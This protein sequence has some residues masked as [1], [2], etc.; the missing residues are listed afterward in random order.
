MKYIKFILPF[1]FLIIL[2]GQ[3]WM[4]SQVAQLGRLCGQH[5]NVAIDF[6]MGFGWQGFYLRYQGKVAGFESLQGQVKVN[7][8]SRALDIDI[9]KNREH[10][11][12]KLN[13]RAY[14][15]GFQN[16]SC[17][18][19]ALEK[20]RRIKITGDIRHESLQWQINDMLLDWKIDKNRLSLDAKQVSVADIQVDQLNMSVTLA[21]NKDHLGSFLSN[22]GGLQWSSVSIKLGA[23][24]WQG[25]NTAYGSP[26]WLGKEISLNL[27]SSSP[28][29]Q[30]FIP[31]QVKV[32]GEI[33]ELKYVMQNQKTN[34]TELYEN[35]RLDIQASDLHQ[36]AER[37][38][39][40]CIKSN[41]NV[42]IMC[43]PEINMLY[44][45]EHYHL[46]EN[47]QFLMS[48]LDEKR[49]VSLH[50]GHES[51]I[52]YDVKIHEVDTCE[53]HIKAFKPSSYKNVGNLGNDQATMERFSISALLDEVVSL[54]PD[55]VISRDLDLGEEGLL[56][57]FFEFSRNKMAHINRIDLASF[58]KFKPEL[59]VQAF[60]VYE[61]YEHYAI[62]DI[63]LYKQNIASVHIN[64]RNNEF[65]ADL[66]SQMVFDTVLWEKGFDLALDHHISILPKVLN[67]ITR[68]SQ[69]LR[70]RLELKNY[71]PL[72]KR[73]AFSLDLSLYW[74]RGLNQQGYR[75]EIFEPVLEGNPSTLKGNIR[76][77]GAYSWPGFKSDLRSAQY[78]KGFD[79]YKNK[80]SFSRI[81]G[82]EDMVS[83]SV[84][85]GYF[86]HKN[87]LNDI[88]DGM[89]HILYECS[90]LNQLK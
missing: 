78:V 27:A 5:Q 21:P 83:V 62:T 68:D 57:Y 29:S 76:L 32:S 53:K 9:F 11:T 15:R 63:H 61:P 77:L 82:Y 3:Y 80:I 36:W 25:K 60:H 28:A 55:G 35:L 30:K 44:Q 4:L 88:Y 26:K 34:I 22:L 71:P 59:R 67:D 42:I 38:L 70:Q 40:S 16:M 20:I 18:T 6:N 37:D 64:F 45:I 39:K 75:L 69:Y 73:E 23:L 79:R 51:K 52:E 31:D 90:Q 89:F 12:P 66:G 72:D 1:I 87:D 47:N 33:N 85:S 2:S 14:L 49:K 58:A 74:E 7:L 48:Y 13:I 41:S 86:D 19:Q 17:Q 54:W 84:P 10:Q 50:H 46:F 43:L 8:I 24:N 65:G 56:F 81:D